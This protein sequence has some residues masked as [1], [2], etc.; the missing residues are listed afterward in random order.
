M[1]ASYGIDTS[2]LVRLVTGDP[3]D[4]FNRCVASLARLIEREDAE[5]FASN[6]VIGEAYVA[7]Q[8]HYGATKPE[9]RSGLESVLQ[10]GLV[11]PL[12]GHAVLDA[13]AQGSGAGFFDRLIA[14]DYERPGLI[15][16]TLDRKMAALSEARLLK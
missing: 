5:V 9:A 6:Q 16:L 13:L 4:G 1:A 10:S 7:L 11:A 3:E 14:D 15:T 12:N 2:I 8:H